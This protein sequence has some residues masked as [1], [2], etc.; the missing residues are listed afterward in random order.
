MWQTVCSTILS[1]ETAAPTSLTLGILSWGDIQAEIQEDQASPEE[2]QGWSWAFLVLSP[3]TGRR[4][5]GCSAA[6]VLISLLIHRFLSRSE[7]AEGGQKWFCG[8][9]VPMDLLGLSTELPLWAKTSLSE[10]QWGQCCVA[11]L[12]SG[13]RT[14]PWS[15]SVS[16]SAVQ[17]CRRDQNG[18]GGDVFHQTQ[19]PEAFPPAA[20]L[21]APCFMSVLLEAAEH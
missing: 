10:P 15:D 2:R 12:Y 8:A 1:R 4:M 9:M 21:S 20:R 7:V 13:G 17:T 6:S 14:V 3:C 11:A 19:L 16:H 5:S 18:K